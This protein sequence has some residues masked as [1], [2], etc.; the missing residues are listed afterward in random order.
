MALPQT[1]FVNANYRKTAH[2][3]LARINMPCF[4][5]G[6]MCHRECSNSVGKHLQY[7]RKTAAEIVPA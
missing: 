5:Q 3:T 6:I 2:V 4:G 7:K 1:C